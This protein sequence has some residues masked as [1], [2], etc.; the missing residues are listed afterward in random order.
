MYYEV[1]YW[2]SNKFGVF[3]NI[4]K[5]FQILKVCECVEYYEMI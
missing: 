2:L 4:L 5:L 3:Y 1:E